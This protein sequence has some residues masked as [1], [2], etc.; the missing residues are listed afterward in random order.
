VFNYKSYGIL[1]IGDDQYLTLL[2]SFGGIASGISRFFWGVL[3]DHFSFKVLMAI[4]NISL[5]FIAVTIQL[6]AYSKPLFCIYVITC[7]F[8]YGGMA[9]MMPAKTY[10]IYG[11]QNGARIYSYIYFGWSIGSILQFLLHF[12]FIQNFGHHGWTLCFYALSV[13][14]LLSVILTFMTHK[15][16]INWPEFYANKL[17]V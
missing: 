11:H 6:V 7:Y 8:L 14:Q 12:T 4:I 10:Q 1:N 13:V 15:L 9:S 3:L 16:E 5:L 2:G 17:N